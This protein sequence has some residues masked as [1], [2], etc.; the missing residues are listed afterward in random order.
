MITGRISKITNEDEKKFG[1]NLICKRVDLERHDKFV[2]Q[3][4][5]YNDEDLIN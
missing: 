4:T 3:N 2:D 5:K 1:V